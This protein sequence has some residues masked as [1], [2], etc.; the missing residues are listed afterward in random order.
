VRRRGTLAARIAPWREG[1]A[2]DKPFSYDSYEPREASS[3][4][5]CSAHADAI[6]PVIEIYRLE[7]G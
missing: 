3:W 1:F 2:S 6:G 7:P 4:A 5:W